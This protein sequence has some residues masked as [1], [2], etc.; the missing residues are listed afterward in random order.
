MT[1]ANY[2][3]LRRGLQL[4]LALLILAALGTNIVI[5]DTPSNLATALERGNVYISPT[6]YSHHKAQPGDAQKLAAQAKRASNQDIPEKFALA[7]P[8]ATTAAEIL[9]WLSAGAFKPAPGDISRLR[10][11][12]LALTPS[13]AGLLAMMAISLTQARRS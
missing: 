7:D 13:M 12:G 1:N 9:A 3:G 6:V 10:A 11:L 8:Q 2:S 4:T 5:A